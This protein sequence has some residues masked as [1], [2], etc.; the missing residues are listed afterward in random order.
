MENQQQGRRSFIKKS[1]AALALMGLGLPSFG[2]IQNKQTLKV[3]LIGCGWYGKMD[4]WRLIQ[5]ANVEVIALC[6]VDQNHLAEANT[7]LKN[8]FSGHTPSLYKDYRDLLKSH[9][10]DITIIGTPDHWHALQTIAALKAGSHV[11]LQK[12]ISVDIIE[13]EAVV[14]ATKKY[15]KIV[16]VGLQRRSTPHLIEA[17]NQ[18]IDTGNLGKIGHVEICCYYHMRAKGNPQEKPIPD[19]LDYDL[20]TGPAPWR[21]YDGLPHKRWWRAFMEYSNGITGD[22]CIHMLDAVRWMLDLGWPTQ[23]S[24][25]GGIFVQKN[26]KSNIAD[27]QT[28]TFEY[29]EFNIVWQHRTWGNPVDPAYPWAFKIFGE[30]A[31]LAGSPFQ[32][33]FVPYGEE[34]PIHWEAV[35]EK[36]K[37]PEDLNEKDI[38]LHAVPATR[39]HFQNLLQAINENRHP[40]ANIYESHISTACCILANLSMELERPLTYDPATRSIPSD[41]EANEKLRRPYRSPWIHPEPDQV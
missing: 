41:S 11:Y 32:A 38:E 40:N 30:N 23:V 14:A 3:A 6:D 28:A 17:K 29:P 19:F 20:W 13:G 37:F 35:Y 25:K 9:Q 18:I 26:E 24:A 5:I 27:T 7:L 34:K 1:A 10:L 31:Y 39:R 4:L 2:H 21:P 12:P 8:R 15:K 36:D 22:M 33:D 16:Q